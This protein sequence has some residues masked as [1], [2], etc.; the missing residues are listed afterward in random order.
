[1]SLSDALTKLGNAVRQKYL[2][3]DKLK[4]DE[5]A[6]L[7]AQ[8]TILKDSLAPAVFSIGVSITMDDSVPLISTVEGGRVALNFSGGNPVGKV[9]AI[10]FKAST[11]V[12]GGVPI[13]VGPISTVMRKQFTITGATMEGYYGTLTYTANNSLSIV[14]PANTSIKMKDLRVWII[15]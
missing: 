2:L 4:L 14:L 1:M 15:S 7:L 9:I 13:E 8:P 11:T 6:D 5:M 12:N 3:K 10:Y